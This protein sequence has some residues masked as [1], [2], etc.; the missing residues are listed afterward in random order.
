MLWKS[1]VGIVATTI[2]VATVCAGADYKAEFSGKVV[3]VTGGSSGIGFQTAL[4]F[5]QN[6]ARVVLAARDSHPSWFNGSAAAERIN[7]DPAVVSAHGSARFVKA[8]VST[9]AGSAAL[10]TSIRATEGDLHIAVNAAG[11]GGPLGLLQDNRKHLNGTHDPI[12]NNLY[13]T[14]RACTH[15]VRLFTE[16]NHS[17]VIVNLAS[18]NGL[19]ATPRGSLY[20]ASKWGIVG[21]TRCLATRYA[22]ATETTPAIRVNALAPTLTDT[23]L[24]WQQTKYMEDNHT[25]PW[26]GSYITHDSPEWQKW[27]PVWINRLVSK[28]I[29]TP[30][31]MADPILYL[32]SSDAS[33]TTG[34]TLAVDRGS[35]A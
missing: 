33:Y 26:E 10:F 20:A 24:T 27:G 34:I 5:A 31:M 35:T 13:A 25:Q 17:G 3:L 6:G 9:H 30:K 2:A 32:C 11:I 4:Q 23:S 15:E 16:K 7:A 18:V 1:V 19:K 29:A 21:L 28:T 8:D 12:R 14:L 22:S